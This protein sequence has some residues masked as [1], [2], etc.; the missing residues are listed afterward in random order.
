[1]AGATSGYLPPAPQA[2]GFW[3]GLSA[4]PQAE[5]HAAGFFSGFSEAP[6]A[7]PQAAGF[8]SGVSA[9]PQEAETPLTTHP[10][11]E[12]PDH[13][14]RFSSAT[15][16]SSAWGWGKDFPGKPRPILNVSR[17]ARPG[18]VARR[19][20]GRER[21]FPALRCQSCPRCMVLFKKAAGSSRISLSMCAMIF[22]LSENKPL[23]GMVL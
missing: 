5:P 14:A 8:F 18:T 1:M 15:T 16:H 11:R 9:A 6:H 17:P 12:L 3:V 23:T 4:A 21:A 19:H 22:S 10:M 2:V 13:S 20:E 7:D